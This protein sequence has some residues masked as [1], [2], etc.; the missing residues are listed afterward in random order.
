MPDEDEGQYGWYPYEAGG[1]VGGPGPQG[2]LV[3]RDEELGDP[4]D[5]EFADARV[6]LERLND[7]KGGAE[8]FA[9]TAQLYG[10]WL[11]HS[12]RYASEGDA[13]AA[14]EEMLPELEN[15]SDRIPEETDKDIEG[16]VRALNEAVAAFVAR[17]MPPAG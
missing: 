6:T 7:A 1:T 13:T 8:P 14:Y 2:G 3:L 12:A 10:G 15:L 11:Q 17:F 4:E 9:V 5:P 16:G